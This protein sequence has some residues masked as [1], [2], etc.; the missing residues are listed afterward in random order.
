LNLSISLVGD[1]LLIEGTPNP[2]H[3]LIKAGRRSDEVHV[4]FNGTGLGSFGPVARILA[5]AGDGDDMVVL[6]PEVKLPTRLEGGP[7]DDCL[8]GGSGPDL[9]FGEDGNDVLIAGTGRPALHAGPGRNRIVVP[10]SMGVIRVAPSADGKVLQQLT[11]AYTLRGVLLSA[12][13]SQGAIST[14]DGV[15]S[16]IILGAADLGD[17][18]IEPLLKEAYEA[19]QAVALTNATGADA[20]RLRLLLGHQGAAEGPPGDA[21]AALIS[22]RKALR[23]GG[24][25]DYST[26]IFA[27]AP[28]PET[29]AQGLASGRDSDERTIELLSRVFSATAIV[30][31][32]PGDSPENNLIQLADSYTV[33][34]VA[35]NPAGSQ[36]QLVNSVWNVRSFQNQTDL[37]YVLQEVDY[38]YGAQQLGDSWQN[39]AKSLLV[40][41]MGVNP[42]VIRPS[43]AT[44][45]EVTTETSGVS[46][47]IGG[48]A[49]WNQQQGFDA[50]ISGGVTISNSKTVIVPPVTITNQSD[51]VTGE[52]D[53]TYDI[54]TPNSAPELV[55]FY[56]QWIWE[57]PFS[58]YSSGQQFISFSLE[59]IA[60]FSVVGV[61][62]PPVVADVDS[63][64][65]LPFGDT[66]TL[67]EPVVL[68]V[69]PT[70]ANAGDT[71]TITGTAL[72][73]SLVTSVLIGGTPVDAGQYTTVS[74]TAI[75]VVAP[76]M[77]GEAL[78]VVVQT[79]QGESNAD[80][81]IEISI[82]DL[83][84]L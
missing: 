39:E 60:T 59:A 34:S 64:V 5:R 31:E 67:G 21:T 14:R 15:P 8:Q 2:D 50:S 27:H 83:C 28:I 32:A 7:G 75:T 71:F 56:N 41:G 45:M 25:M 22:V 82:F 49:G 26:G 74:D 53:W 16:P 48:S 10:H 51:T 37:Y 52:T 18:R 36:V 80:V 1:T 29:L 20:A 46:G 19:G 43:P 55:T 81:T 76:D 66:F 30:P 77:S 24:A 12:D 9:L 23:P 65:P 13:K 58:T 47:S 6:G 35:Q 44:T 4:V 17:A 61:K 54:Q 11:N 72:Y 42:A 57:V 3:I 68:S 38:R 73:P 79:T 69:N 78:S 84:N 63:T 33:Q 70:C 40:L 62:L